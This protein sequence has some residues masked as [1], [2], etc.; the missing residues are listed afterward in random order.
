MRG[1]NLVKPCAAQVLLNQFADGAQTVRESSSALRDVEIR[2]IH[3]WSALELDKA[4]SPYL[5]G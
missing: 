3:H 1:Q 2:E 5:G 4:I